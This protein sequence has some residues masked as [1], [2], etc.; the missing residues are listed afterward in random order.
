M[1]I[2]GNQQTSSASKPNHDEIPTSL[3][4]ILPMEG[5]YIALLDQL[6][7]SPNY[8]AFGH[9]ETLYQAGLLLVGGR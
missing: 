1:P 7:W 5:A 8:K 6:I 3:K 2:F 9:V 4:L